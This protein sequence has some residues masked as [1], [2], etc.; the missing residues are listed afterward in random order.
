M[1]H[2][3]CLVS[4][5]YC[6]LPHLWSS[7][8]SC[9]LTM[10]QAPCYVVTGSDSMFILWEWLT[11]SRLPDRPKLVQSEAYTMCLSLKHWDTWATSHF[12][13]IK[14]TQA[15]TAGTWGLVWCGYFSS[16]GLKMSNCSKIWKKISHALFLFRVYPHTSH[17]LMCSVKLEWDAWNW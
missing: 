5:H 2:Q 17:T 6:S 9:V 7:L 3:L 4:R 14:Y 15:D 10:V 1:S 8:K 16:A 12:S 11:G 13:C